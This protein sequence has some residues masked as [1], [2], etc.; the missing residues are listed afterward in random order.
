M[1]DQ[2]NQISLTRRVGDI[3]ASFSA[4]KIVEI[5]KPLSQSQFGGLLLASILA[6]ISLVLIIRLIENAILQL[7]ITSFT[8]LLLL[9]LGLIYWKLRIRLEKRNI[10]SELINTFADA[11]EAVFLANSDGKVIFSNEVFRKLIQGVNSEDLLGF[12]EVSSMAKMVVPATKSNFMRLK[13]NALMGRRVDSEIEVKVADEKRHFWHVSV[14]PVS[15][16]PSISIWTLKDI[17]AQREYEAKRDGE[18]KFKYDLLDELPV[19]L[20]SADQDGNLQYINKTLADWLSLSGNGKKVSKP[21][22]LADFIVLND[23]YEHEPAINPDESGM[24]GGLQYKK[25]EQFSSYLIQSQKEN[26]KGD[27][28]YSRSVV[29]RDPFTPIVDD[30]TGGTLLRRI[31]WLFSDSPVGIVILDLHGVVMDCNRSFLKIL[32]LHRDGV[33]GLPISDRISKEDRDSASAAL[34]KVAMKTMPAVPLE[35]RIPADGEREIIASFY[36]SGIENSDSDVTGLALHVRDTTDEKNLEV[37]F[38]QAQKMQLI[39]QLTGGV[40]HNFNNLLTAMGGFCDL[41]LSRHGPKDPDYSDIMQIKKNTKRAT[42]LVGD[43]LAF[44]RRQTWQPK[45]FSITD[46]LNSVSDT[47]RRLIGEN[48]E[49]NLL[50][51][52]DVGLIRTDRTQFEQVVINLAVN[53]RDAMPGGGTISITTKLVSVET[54]VQRGHDVMPAGEYIRINVADTGSGIAQEDITRI[55]EPFFST[56]NVGEGTGLGLSTV[57]GIIRQ[58]DG[59]IFVDSSIIG[60]GT[61][62]EI[63]LPAFTAAEATAFGG[64]ISEGG[65]LE[66]AIE[67]DL[68]GEATVLL[69]EDEDAVRVFGSRAL[70]NNGYRVLEAEDGEQALDVINDFDDPIDLI[71]TDVMMPGMDGHTLVKLVQE[72]LPDIKVILMSGYAED[73]IP[74]EIAED[75]SINFLPKPF[76]LQE[77]AGKVKEVMAS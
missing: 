66:L 4:N 65:E 64:E 62:F 35:V 74:G 18:Q 29:L 37:Q 54:A 16:L 5:F 17:T 7:V 41:L 13:D 22:S 25:G 26:N 52:K 77:L 49:L 11:E 32:G 67:Q 45:I 38:N 42:D 63:Y 14:D 39:G 9:I 58:S 10:Q 73:A 55:W 8:T 20:F 43:L 34:A 75:G 36:V 44:S 50:H 72:E 30:G 28:M 48:I 76:S 61:T 53:S 33:V 15:S 23:I 2:N 6:G 21:H 1:T 59:F 27:F 69:V 3:V 68:T 24:H 31:P 56:K 12:V 46:E 60:D 70:T 57:Y 51:G 40:A 71:I 47:L 19:G